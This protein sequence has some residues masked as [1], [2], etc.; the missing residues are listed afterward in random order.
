MP[1]PRSAPVVSSEL[2]SPK[3]PQASGYLEQYRMQKKRPEYRMY[4]ID[5]YR[6][7]KNEMNVKPG[8]LGPDLE[9]DAHKE[10]VR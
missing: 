1:K 2:I 6:R 9:S 4:T 3:G 8:M 5:D 7:L 10:R